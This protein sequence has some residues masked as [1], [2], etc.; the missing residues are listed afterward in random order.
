MILKSRTSKSAIFA[1]I[2][3]LATAGSA[4]AAAAPSIGASLISWDATPGYELTLTVSGGGEVHRYEFAAGETASLSISDAEGRLLAD[5]NY[6]WQLSA[7]RELTKEEAAAMAQARAAGV[8]RTDKAAGGFSD[9]GYFTVSGGA[10][11]TPSAFEDAE[12]AQ[13]VTQDQII[14]GSQCVGIDCT[15]SESFGFDTLR[16]KENNLRIKFDDT[17]S[18][19]SFPNND[20]QLTANESDNG[21]ANK[22][23]IDDI[24]GGKTPFTVEAGAP[25]HSLYVDDAGNV[26]VNTSTPVVEV[27]IK[28][29]DSPTLRLEQDGSSGFQSQTWDIAGNETNFFVRDVTHSSYLPFKIL[30]NAGHNAL[31]IAENTGDI[32]IGTASPQSTVEIKA[33][34]P[35]LRFNGTTSSEQWEIRVNDVGRLNFQNVGTGNNAM[36]IGPLA[37]N[38]LLQIG[39]DVANQVEIDGTLSLTGTCTG[40]DAVFTDAFPLESIEDHAASMW[41]N[42]YLP[43]VGPTQEG[44]TSINVFEKTT[45]ILQELEIAH[46]YIEQLHNGLKD[47][48]ERISQLHDGLQDKDE[49]ISRLEEA[50]AQ[51]MEIIEAR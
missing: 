18:S 20:W 21:G 5:G 24:T 45:G 2:L 3:C 38:N 30:P 19:A 41:K 13:V 51:L 32:G 26:G 48:D 36:Q 31:V 8:S 7:A 14:Q 22:F 16:L 9:T 35:E 37:N 49:R 12:K 4:A 50:V 39:R 15:S 44:P 40:C 23:S 34:F 43:G 11:A 25:S 6:T 42:S 47:K 10:F 1:L 27:H 28:D 17:S 33:D 46:I 29:G